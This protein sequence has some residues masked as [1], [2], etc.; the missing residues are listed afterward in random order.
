M[1]PKIDRD[2]SALEELDQ[3]SVTCLCSGGHC[4]F[5]GLNFK[6]CFCK[7]KHGITWK[8]RGGVSELMDRRGVPFLLLK[9]YPKI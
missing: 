2:L 9:W 6:L 8:T 7:K 1:V 4:M 3:N 5:G